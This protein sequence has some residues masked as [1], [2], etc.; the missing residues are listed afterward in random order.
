MQ[1]YCFGQGFLDYE[2]IKLAR[3]SFF[4]LRMEKQRM[5]KILLSTTAMVGAFALSHAAA[6]Q[7]ATTAP[8]T[9]YLGGKIDYHAGIVREKQ[10]FQQRDYTSEVDSSVLLTV[11]SNNSD[12]VDYGARIQLLPNQNDDDATDEYVIYVEGQYGTVEVGAADGAAER[13][14]VTAP[15]DFGTGGVKGQYAQFATST[16]HPDGLRTTA[17]IDNGFYAFDDNGATKITYFS[18]RFEGFQFGASFSPD[19][20]QTKNNREG[21][22]AGTAGTTNGL[23]NVDSFDN[24]RELVLNYEGEFEGVG[25][26]GS[27]GYV[28]ADAKENRSVPASKFQD[29]NA[30]Q[31]GLQLGYEGFTF[32]GGYVTQGESGYRQNLSNND[33]MEA[34]NVGLQYETGPFIVGTNALFS[35]NEGDQTV[36]GDDKLNAY[37]VGVTYK[38]APGLS[39]YVEGTNFNYKGTNS[40]TAFNNDATVVIL[41]TSL[42][43]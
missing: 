40:S 5:K 43:F 18:P 1:K 32:G 30:I 13:L 28:G 26:K 35:R 2:P 39:T 20:S 4:S 11:K 27:L 6:A 21:T 42:A 29:L 14:A 23:L 38:V 31:T 37:S 15:S 17:G 8:L 41:G 24:Y 25:V 36:R 33:E 22:F 19:G 12:V 9:I 7:T 3:L 34:Y 10:N 16:G